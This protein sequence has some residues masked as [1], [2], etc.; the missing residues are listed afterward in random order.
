VTDDGESGLP[1]ADDSLGF[2]PEESEPTVGGEG[3]G[4]G[5]DE[6]DALYPR[7]RASGYQAGATRVYGGAYSD[8][9]QAR[10]MGRLL[11]GNNL[12]DVP[13]TERRGRLPD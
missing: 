13:F 9:D 12:G 11:D 5:V 7:L 8:E 4:L 3:K 2:G 6:P 10:G 1:G